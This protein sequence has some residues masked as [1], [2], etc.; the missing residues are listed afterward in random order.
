ML[1]FQ[2]SPYPERQAE[3]SE[4]PHYKSSDESEQTVFLVDDDENVR[5][6]LA[7]FLEGYH[8][9]VKTFSN[10]Q[11]FLEKVDPQADGC[12]I[13][14]VR[15]PGLTG[16][17]VQMRLKQMHASFPI[18]VLTAH[19]DV[20]V[21]VESIKQGA[22]DFLL[23]SSSQHEIISTVQEALKH[24]RRNR[25]IVRELNRTRALM[26][27]LSKR[28]LEVVDLVIEGL[29]SREI[30]ERLDI[31]IKTV[32]A[33]RANLMRKMGATNVADLINKIVT[34]RNT[35]YPKQS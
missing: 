34:L 7:F 8:L 2:H 1:N 12:L 3:T 5:N 32:D 33:H 25:E 13:L 4:T 10:G 35:D 19:A 27:S 17:E 24:S 6:S 9:N 11:E 23:K 20:P 29:T 15:M 21:A 22:Y 30:S 26:Q 31:K 16:T 28:E 18:I 14:D